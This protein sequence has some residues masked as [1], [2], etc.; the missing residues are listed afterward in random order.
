[1]WNKDEMYKGPVYAC[2]RIGAT[3]LIR[4]ISG[5]K[6]V[7]MHLSNAYTSLHNK[8]DVFQAKCPNMGRLQGWF[9]EANW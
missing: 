9:A 6:K 4:T 3:H 5:G 8:N 1:M 7:C 2:D